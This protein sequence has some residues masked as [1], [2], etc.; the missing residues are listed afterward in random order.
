M[1]CVASKL[2]HFL[3]LWVEKGE[4]LSLRLFR[5]QFLAF[6]ESPPNFFDDFSLLAL[7]SSLGDSPAPNS[8]VNCVL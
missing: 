7:F 6:I 5:L 3:F 8:M 2:C 1:H 4:H